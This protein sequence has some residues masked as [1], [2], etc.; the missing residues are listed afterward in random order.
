VT[1]KG[2]PFA[3]FG[4]VRQLRGDPGHPGPLVVAGA[5]ELVPVLARDLREGGDAASVREG[6]SP[7]G[8]AA[9]I[10]IGP[11]DE[12]VLRQASRN[13][14]PIVG[15]TDGESLPYVLDTDLVTVRRGQGFPV[16]EIAGVL[17]RLLRERGTSLAG[18][19][20]VLRDAVIDQLIGTASKH[21]AVIA[22]GVFIPGVGF[23]I[24]TLNQIRLVLSIARAN[25]FAVDSAVLPEAL[26]VVGAGLG[27]RTIARELLD[28]VPLAGWVVKGGIAYTGTRAVGEAAR[29]YFALRRSSPASPSGPGPT[30]PA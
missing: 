5:K 20:P 1:S 4:A 19:L 26:G 11:A 17:A 10:W 15:V 16:D 28:L 8:A 29:R 25:G 2:G 9:L 23:P 6:G 24:L 7:V 18:R 12:E 30:L 3:L 14:V 22:I 21:N 27:W 13:K